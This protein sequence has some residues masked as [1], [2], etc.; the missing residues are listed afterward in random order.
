MYARRISKSQSYEGEPLLL[1]FGIT[2]EATVTTEAQDLAGNALDQDSTIAG[3][4]PKSWKFTV[5][6]QGSP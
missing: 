6:R 4:Q 3:E 5:R 2:Y 1:G